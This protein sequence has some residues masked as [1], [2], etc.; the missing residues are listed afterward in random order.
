MHVLNILYA[1]IEDE[2]MAYTVIDMIHKEVFKTSR[3][4][5]WLDSS[6]NSKSQMLTFGSI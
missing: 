4:T 5:K 6:L 1:K 2:L 3:H